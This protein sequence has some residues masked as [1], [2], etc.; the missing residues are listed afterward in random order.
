MRSPVTAI[1]WELWRTS[2]LELLIRVGGLLAMTILI[3][4]I[5]WVH[6][7]DSPTVRA[8][9]GILLM[10][11][12]AV[13]AASSTWILALESQ[14]KGFTLRLGFARPVTTWLMVVLPVLYSIL[15][16]I[17]CFLIS[18]S[19]YSWAIGTSVPLAGPCVF[20]A[21]VVAIFLAATWSPR[22]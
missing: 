17:G 11:A 4:A 15:A 16:S 6:P 18:M 5:A 7:S 10:V 19:L 8:I 9:N 20:I 12:G 21:C 3:T 14:Q 2:R 22:R 13:S 1:I